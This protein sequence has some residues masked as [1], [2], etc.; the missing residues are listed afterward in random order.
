MQKETT[1]LLFDHLSNMPLY[2][3]I[4]SWRYLSWFY[5]LFF[6]FTVYK[7]I[8]TGLRFLLHYLST[9]SYQ[10]TKHWTKVKK[11]T[12]SPNHLKCTHYFKRLELFFSYETKL[13]FPTSLTTDAYYWPNYIS[14]LPKFRI[15]MQSYI[16]AFFICF[17]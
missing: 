4:F 6:Y 17:P 12:N 9:Y 14:H 2:I 8:N 15:I 7:H 16:I 11:S 13:Y 10:Q 5:W 1:S 3:R